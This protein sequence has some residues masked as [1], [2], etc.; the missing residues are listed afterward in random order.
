MSSLMGTNTKAS[1]HGLHTS[2]SVKTHEGSWES[3]VMESVSASQ[4]T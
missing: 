2:F 4:R 1:T 3:G